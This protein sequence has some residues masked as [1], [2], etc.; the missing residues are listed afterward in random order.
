MA[1]YPDLA[2]SR[3]QTIADFEDPDQ[4]AMFRKASGETLATLSIST[5]QTRKDTG[6]SSLQVSLTNRGDQILA[7]DQP[8][9]RWPLPHDWSRYHLLLVSVHSSRDLPGF[10]TSLCSGTQGGLAYDHPAVVLQ[11]GWNLIRMDLATA[12]EYL[13]LRDVR[14]LRFGCP[15]LEA[16][17]DL[18]L[19]DIILVDNRKLLFGTPTLRPHELYAQSA[20]QRLFIGSAERF[21]LAFEN[22]LVA[23]WYDL[24]RDTNR[25]RNL[26]GGAPL[27]PRITLSAEGGGTLPA[28]TDCQ[29][30][31]I[32][33]SEMRMVLEGRCRLASSGQ[34]TGN[35]ELRWQYTIY[36]DG[37]VCLGYS[38]PHA[39]AGGEAYTYSLRI[40]CDA[41]A[42]F[43]RHLGGA[44]AG[45]TSY[46]LFSRAG[47]GL[48]DLL[49]VPSGPVQP[50]TP[51]DNADQI[52]IAW[53]LPAGDEGVSFAG[54]LRIWPPDIDSPEQ[55][56]VLAADYAEPLPI[57][58]DIGSLSPTEQGD[59]DNDGFIE[60]EGCYALR[61][62]G[63]LAR[64]RLDGRRTLRFSPVFKIVN[65][66]ACDVWAYRDGRQMRRTCRDLRGNVLF[67]VEGVITNEVLIEVHSVLKSAVTGGP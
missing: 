51:F 30:Q 8:G 60:S 63:N 25:V 5:E 61:L 2:G 12:G 41:Q 14:E 23:G 45:S 34:P 28:A 43:V 31:L 20:G 1:A 59:L 16:P 47:R 21:E 52:G 19:D 64:V 39:S 42:D 49:I 4:A 9:S 24:G 29:Q 17:V 26:A 54:M 18:F 44:D 10:S 35:G 7:M 40:G 27:G 48:A 67:M 66:S 36:P 33:L 56:L 62:D 6:R 37:R 38:S 11:A 58:V 15:E 46:A 13:D 22:G 50:P 65:S 3:F 55:A 53:E 57:A 32:E